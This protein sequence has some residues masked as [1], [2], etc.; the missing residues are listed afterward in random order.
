[1][2]KILLLA[3]FLIV[4]S[5]TALA[6]GEIVQFSDKLN[7]W[8]AESHTVTVTNNGAL[9]TQV[10]IPV[11]LGFIY[12]SG[13]C[14]HA[15]GTI[16]CDL[17]PGQTKSYTL[18][19]TTANSEYTLSTFSP[20]TNNTYTGNSVSFL[21]IKDEEIFHTLVEY[22]R[23]RGNYFFDSFGSGT[24][25]SGHTGTGCAYLP[26]STMFELNF[27]HKVLNIKQYFSLADADAEDVIFTCTYP[28][29]TVVRSHLVTNI[30][31][32]GSIWSADY[33]IS[34]IE[35]SWERMGYLGM[36]FDSGEYSIGSNV[37]VNCTGLQYTL[38]EAHGNITVDE[39][40]FD[41]EIRD[42]EPFS[43]SASTSTAAIGN[44]TQ[45]VI[46]SYTVT[47]NEV[48]SA[49][50]VI[51][52]IDAPS[53]A[54]F[55]GTRGELWGTAQDTYRLE[56]TELQAGQ[57]ETI[58]LVARFDTSS[59]P[60]INT[61]D[62]TQG[63]KVRYTT[64]WE[65][66]AYNPQEY[67]QYLANPSNIS[68]N[69]GTSVQVVD[70]ID[71][72]TSLNST[73][74]NVYSTV[75]IINNT[76]DDIYNLSLAI[77]SSIENIPYKVWTFYSRNLTYYPPVASYNM[78]FTG[79]FGGAGGGVAC[80]W[81]QT[82][83]YN[84]S[85]A[86][87]DSYQVYGSRWLRV[88]FPS[89]YQGTVD[90]FRSCYRIAPVSGT[91]AGNDVLQVFI[92]NDYDGSGNPET[93]AGC[94]LVDA[95][96]LNSGIFAADRFKWECTDILG[97]EI[98]S[99]NISMLFEC[100]N[101][102]GTGDGWKI[103]LDPTADLNYTYNSTD[104][105]SSWTSETKEGLVE[106]DWCVPIDF[107]YEV[108]YYNNRSLTQNVTCNAGVCDLSQLLDQFN[109]TSGA[110]TNKMCEIIYAINETNNNM[111]NT[112][113]VMNS[114]LND[115]R[116]YSQ[117]IY[118]DTQSILDQLNCNGTDDSSLCDITLSI[119]DSVTNLYT[120]ITN[121]NNTV[122]SINNTLYI[123]NQTI[124]QEFNTTYNTI[125]NISVD[126]D[127][128]TVSINCSSLTIDPTNESICD[129]I[130]RIDNNVIEMN[131]TLNEVLGTVRYINGTRW[132]N[133]TAWDLYEAIQNQS[134]EVTVNTEEILDAIARLQEF[135]EELVFL[136]TDAFGLQQS[137][138]SDIN[139]GDISSA[140]Q[141]LQKANDRLN[142]AAMELVEKQ[143]NASEQAQQASGDF[144][145]VIML[146]LGMM[147]V[148]VVL[149]YLFSKP[150]V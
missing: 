12:N 143:N 110:S 66:N 112:I 135:D 51:I 30:Q 97:K 43:I 4:F 39:D 142:Q 69:M 122:N 100:E 5:S 36:N 117:L 90:I 21:R 57:S 14:T 85:L 11:Q 29:N 68:V 65:S 127:N 141:K 76:V 125:N 108:W 115:V 87:S 144:A 137:A 18:D 78:T 111:W 25:G 93:E 101:C 84:D 88:D 23:G 118:S 140:A 52:E 128:L 38:P 81:N 17:A 26:N 139:N 9:D 24:A 133:V 82:E 32:T 92:C 105:G 6:A 61:V 22:G 34:N 41:L 132:G 8:D 37:S 1:M 114:T 77:N 99:D 35:G 98:F 103:A 10:T 129:A 33:A 71:L 145:W 120:D 91:S 106:W 15:A 74:N 49:D 53:Y 40:S 150:R 119:N 73:V 62:L 60:G 121:I 31:R 134:T 67:T 16:T 55:I 7:Y 96:D 146:G 54:A 48:Y 126:L 2:K 138:K 83:H 50:N 130:S 63:V 124:I 86:D 148:A 80:R 75:N 147:I 59:A 95:H 104:D 45:E 28:N 113:Q 79:G 13:T 42:R 19:S 149:F 72:L 46:I 64:C 116:D 27:L 131:S 123:L 70:V 107:G 56:L 47:N 109:C 58:D 94:T 44:G 102:A 3:I 136:V 89:L 20:S